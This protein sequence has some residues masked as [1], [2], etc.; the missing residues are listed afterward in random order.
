MADIFS[1]AK[2]SEVM[3]KIRSKE[4]KLET[5]FRKAL[6]AMG[7]RYRKNALGW[8]GKPDLLLKKRKTVVF[9]DSCFWHGCEKHFKLPAT[10]KTFWKTKIDRNRQRDREVT[11]HY[12]KEGWKIIR[13]WEH[14]IKKDLTS[15]VG[16]VRLKI[17][18]L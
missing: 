8:F 14:E 9:V 13:V 16:R 11:R 10:K 6:W 18:N 1:K 5:E 7:Y 17:G 4:T 3:S 12:K 2:R 15:A